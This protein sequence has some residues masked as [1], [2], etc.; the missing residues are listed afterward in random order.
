MPRYSRE[1]WKTY[2]N[3]FDLFTERNLIKLQGQGLFDELLSPITL[4]KEANVFTAAKADQLVVLKIYRTMN[5]NFNTMYAYLAQDERYQNIKSQK[6]KVIF[7]WVQREY[8]NL[9]LARE[10]VS[11]PTPHTFRDNIIIMDFIGVGTTPSPMLKDAL[12]E[13]LQKFY[14]ECRDALDRLKKAGLVHGD[15]SAFNILNHEE[16]PVFID[17]SQATTVGSPRAAELF[18]RD[19]DNLNIFFRKHGV[20]TR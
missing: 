2:K 1:A 8:A 4:G 17:F 15:I 19:V 18:A 13:N 16:K 12:P 5:A 6:R 11:V 3:V 20:Q 7:A 9:L 10:Y 14:D